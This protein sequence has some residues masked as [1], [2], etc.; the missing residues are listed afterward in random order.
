[1]FKPYPV[2]QPIIRDIGMPIIKVD[3]AVIECRLVLFDLDGTL[4]DKDFRNRSLAE[5]RMNAIRRLVSEDAAQLWA[6]L[7]GVDPAT[8]NVDI[9]GPLSK[10]PRREDLTVATAAIWLNRM[11]WFKA[12]ELAA[13]AYASA[14]AQQSRKYKPTLIKGAESALRGMKDAGLMLGVATN[15]SGR[16]ARDIM[17]SIGVEPLF[18]VFIGADEVPEGKPA[19]DM[20]LAACERLGVPPEEAVYVGDEVVDAVAGRAAGVREVVVV[21]AE[22]DVSRYTRNVVDS[23]AGIK[24]G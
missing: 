16:T 21:N 11:D 24:T 22:D 4:V 10:A 20:I 3:D 17:R 7:S 2:R 12:R 8:F 14:D 5:A 15:G 9:R 23:V 1:L 13:E 18:D 19:P 6:T